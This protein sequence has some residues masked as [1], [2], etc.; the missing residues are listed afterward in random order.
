MDSYEGLLKEHTQ[1]LEEADVKRAKAYK[2]TFNTPTG[3]QVLD[4][5]KTICAINVPTGPQSIEQANYINGAQSV[6]F[7]IVNYL[8]KQLDF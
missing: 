3:K 6:Y 2:T 7:R 5:L 4:D 1:A 8:Q